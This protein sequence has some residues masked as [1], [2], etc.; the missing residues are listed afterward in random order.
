MSIMTRIMKSGM[1]GLHRDTGGDYE[2]LSPY[3]K[4]PFILKKAS[5]ISL[6]KTT[7]CSDVLLLSISIRSRMEKKKY[8]VIAISDDRKFFELREIKLWMC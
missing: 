2:S 5:L 1:R 4:T 8:R 6:L 3:Y 7:E